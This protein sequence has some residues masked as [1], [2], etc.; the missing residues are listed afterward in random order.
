MTLAPSQKPHESVIDRS[1]LTAIPDKRT[2]LELARALLTDCLAEPQ[3]RLAYPSVA[4][5][6]GLNWLSR[7]G[8]AT[9]V[10]HLWRGQNA[11][12]VSAEF[13]LR[14]RAAYYAAVGRDDLR[15]HELQ[16]T[17]AAFHQQGVTSAAFK[18]AAL[19]HTVYPDSACRDMGDLDFWILP[20]Q[21]SQAQIV[22]ES[23]GYQPRFNPIRP[24]ALN[25][26][27]GGEIQY[28]APTPAQSLVELHWGVF[29][30]EW[31]QHTAHIAE[32]AIWARTQFVN[33]AGQPAR[34]LDP[35]DSLIQICVHYTIGH[36]FSV[37]WLRTLV[38][39]VLL[40]RHQPLDWPTII[41]RARDWRVATTVWLM[42]SLAV[43]L[44]DLDEAAGTVQQLA[45]S[46]LRRKLIGLF[47]N[48]DAL[49]NMRDLGR[50][51]WR[52]VYLLLMVDRKRDMLKL[53]LRALWPE[54]EWLIARY[55][56]YTF[57]TR[58][59]H[60]FGAARGRI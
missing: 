6:L 17:L 34:I 54:R 4:A 37:P 20:H 12:G 40:A 19:A 44:C 51:R 56:H 8:L 13:A 49:V 18:G 39:V 47:A 58:W 53:V 31:V 1:P 7:Q 26:Q 10:W 3:N 14:D 59:R 2:R 15:R 25:Q 52:Y 23:L 43:D 36:N 55:G 16:A 41:A 21:M 29:P 45:P 24:P 11:A 33:L 46:W 57:S 32:S 42:L 27:N 50:S 28:Y 5:Q 38:D 9:L 60:L 30:G 48:P 22:M 35:A